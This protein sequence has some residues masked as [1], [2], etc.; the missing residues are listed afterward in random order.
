[1]LR[2]VEADLGTDSVLTGYES[3]LE[4]QEMLEITP[5]LYDKAAQLRA[6]FSSLKTPDSLHLATAL[7]HNCDEFWTNDNRP[8]SVARTLVRNF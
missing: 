6:A 1:M 5:D 2:T 4:A 8:D 7:R 3:F